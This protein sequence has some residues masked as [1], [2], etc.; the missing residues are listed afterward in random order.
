MAGSAS[1]NNKDLPS[2]M[3]LL[4]LL[5]KLASDAADGTMGVVSSPMRNQSDGVPPSCGGAFNDG[6]D[7]N[8]PPILPAGKNPVTSTAAACCAFC[9]QHKSTCKAWTWNQHSN[10]ICYIKSSCNSV[11]SPGVVSG[12]APPLPPG[13]KPCT[14]GMCWNFTYT[15]RVASIEQPEWDRDS[16]ASR[17]ALPLNFTWSWGTKPVTSSG[18]GWTPVTPFLGQVDGAKWK[19]QYPNSGGLWFAQHWSVQHITVTSTPPRPVNDTSLWNVECRLGGGDAMTSPTGNLIP[20]TG[21]FQPLTA[22]LWGNDLGVLVINDIPWQKN[23]IVTTMLAFNQRQYGPSFASAPGVLEKTKHFPI[24]DCYTGGDTDYNNAQWGLTQLDRIGFHG[25]CYDCSGPNRPVAEILK[26][27]GQDLTVGAIPTGTPFAVPGTGGTFNTSV[28]FGWADKIAQ[29]YRASGWNVSRVS[30]IA[31]ADEPG[32]YFPNSSPDKYM[33]TSTSIYARRVMAEWVAYLQKQTPPLTPADFGQASWATVVPSPQRWDWAA[34]KALPLAKK[35][36]FYW[37]LKFSVHGSA[38]AFSRATTALEQAFTPGVK[39]FSNFNNFHGRTYQPSGGANDG[40]LLGEDMFAFARNRATTL[41]WTEDWFDDGMS[42]QWSYYMARFRSAARL[43]PTKDVEIG[44]YIVGRASSG[45]EVQLK[46][47]AQ[48]AGGAKSLR[49]YT[50]GPEYNFPG[51]SYTDL[52]PAQLSSFMTGMA[53]THEMIAKAED[54]LWTAR[55]SVAQ[56]AILFPQSATYWDLVGVAAGGGIIEDFTNHYLDDRTT[57]Y[58]AEVWGLWQAMSLY[59]NIPADFVDEAGLL[60][61][62]TL[63]P[64][65]VLIVTEPDLPTAGATA[66]DEWVQGGGTLITVSNAGTSDQYHDP[67]TVL[68]KLSGMASKRNAPAEGGLYHGERVYMPSGYVAPIVKN[69]TLDAALCPDMT[70]CKFAARG[71]AGDFVVAGDAADVAGGAQVLGTYVNGNP[72]IKSTVAGK[73][74]YIHFAWLPGLSFS[75]GGGAY[76]PDQPNAIASMLQHM[77][78]AAGV[79]APVSVS[80][81]NVEAPMLTGPGG[82]VVTV[83]NHAML[84]KNKNMSHAEIDQLWNKTGCLLPAP[85]WGYAHWG[86]LPD[87]GVSDMMTYCDHSLACPKTNPGC[88]KWAGTCA[89]NTTG[90]VA[91]CNLQPTP[92]GG[93]YTSPGAPSCNAVQDGI[94]CGDGINILPAGKEPVVSS[95]AACCALCQQHSSTCTAWTWNQRSNQIC[96]IKS[97]CNPVASPGV[98]SGGAPPLNLPLELNITLGYA[99]SSVTSM[100]LGV[101]PHTVLVPGTVSVKLPTFQLAD[102]IVFKR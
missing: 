73:G 65:K 56:V 68:A 6:V 23:I 50:F 100:Q 44:G 10:H 9:Q 67:S 18:T 11:A 27:L 32:W 12:G 59:K 84:G 40:A 58:L 83:L 86:G 46:A 70:L 87:H 31:I 101:L 91:A 78:R 54:I 96:Y 61:P 34:N 28:M 55:R 38:V 14:S 82:D 49:Y 3:L 60:E 41:L 2:K 88:D 77:L 26:S 22:K 85:T 42:G 95:A 33:N 57:D 48:V 80:V 30:N 7:C 98:V 63:K 75:Y 15:C 5:A 43:A 17:Q 21:E 4:L 72:A 93:L 89:N 64:F 25:L 53:N 92:P 79:R 19:R 36:L 37:T 69:G 13:S 66:L 99:P 74:S 8:D 24:T 39:A 62:E 76:Q 20:L 1:Y 52:P 97:S 71:A 94:N 102:M 35:K 16:P 29:P 47:L 81:D 45:Q 90:P 51:N